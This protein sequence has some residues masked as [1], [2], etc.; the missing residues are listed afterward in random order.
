MQSAA[1][2]AV[3]VLEAVTANLQEMHNLVSGITAAVDGG[4]RSDSA[5]LSQLAEMLRTEVHRFVV[6]VRQS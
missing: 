5:G 1:G 2:D 6:T 3:N 4:G